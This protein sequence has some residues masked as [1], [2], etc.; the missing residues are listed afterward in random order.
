MS[1]A[2]CCEMATT[3]YFVRGRG[4]IKDPRDI[5]NIVLRSKQRNAG[6]HSQR[7][8]RTSRPGIRRGVAELDGKGETVGGIV[9]MRYGENAPTVIDGIKKKLR[10]ISSRRCPR[11]CRWC[12]FMTA[13]ELIQRAIDTSREKLIEE[14]GSW[15]RWFA[16]V[17]LWHVRSALVAIITLPIGVLIL[18]FIPMLQLGLTS[19]I[20]SLGGIAIAIGAMVDA[21]IIMVEN[22][23]RRLSMPP[24]DAPREP[25]DPGGRQGGGA[26]ALLRPVGA[27]VSFLPIFALRGERTA[28]S[29]FGLYQ[30]LCHGRAAL[31]AITLVPIL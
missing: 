3:E 30:D 31:L 2:R 7:R 25:P 11:G 19:N 20:M 29:A 28:S 13:S 23:H 10:Q 14:I 5:E 8:H 17:F 18:P 26:I 4:Y 6:L 9:V 12:R 27:H 15:S 22:A 16:F 21:A 1:A 24:P